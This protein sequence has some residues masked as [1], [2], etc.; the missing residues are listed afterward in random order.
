MWPLSERRRKQYERLVR[1][2]RQD[3]RIWIDGEGD[4][5]RRIIEKAKATLIVDR[6]IPESP[7]ARVMWM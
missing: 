6:E 4:R 2:L 7:Y 1:R 5:L 3:D